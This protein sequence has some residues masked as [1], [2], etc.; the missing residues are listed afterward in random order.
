MS[1]VVLLSGGFSQ[2]SDSAKALLL[3][4]TDCLNIVETLDELISTL[5]DDRPEML[6]ICHLPGVYDGI[7]AAERIRE[8]L[9]VTPL[10]LIAVE[11]L[12]TLK[13]ALAI[14]AVAIVEPPLTEQAV[15]AAFKRCH[16][17]SE[18]IQQEAQ[19]HTRNLG[20]SRITTPLQ[21]D[22][23]P[24]T[25]L[26]ESTQNLCGTFSK[27]PGPATVTDR[28]I[29][30]TSAGTAVSNFAA[31][32]D[33]PPKKLLSMKVLVAEDTPM[34]QMTIR[35]QLESIGC[36]V[37]IA[38]NGKEACDKFEGEAFDAILMDLRMPEMD[39]FEATRLIRK[40]ELATGGRIPVVA[41]TSY[42]LREIMDKCLSIG[43]DGYLVKPVPTKKLEATLQH[44]QKPQEVS[45][46]LES[47]VSVLKDLPVIDAGSILEDLDFNIELYRELI[48]M[49]LENYTGHAEEL[50]EMLG[51]A[52]L[53]DIMNSAHTLKG[54]V[55]NIGGKR[56]SEVARLIQNMC[57]EGK[58]PLST[59]WA[60]VLSAES[61]ALKASL[62]TVNYDDLR[63]LENAE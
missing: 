48:D 11:S 6:F 41:L 33:I 35:Q 57:H 58:M 21:E 13:A 8:F 27:D 28:H 32:R 31:P 37:T 5:S 19:M 9:P 39:G 30:T 25:D 43:M 20:S 53:T 16:R 26:L 51:D 15:T 29:P 34:L 36:Q 44:L 59:I 52:T 61:A 49:Y 18:A 17:Q 12:D 47:L 38:S 22:S 54:I 23:E 7:A 63:N 1:K 3:A 42:T 60:P 62:V 45:S 55:S 46:Q 10:A 50:A 2:W 14:G 24:F 40:R 56:L 4:Q